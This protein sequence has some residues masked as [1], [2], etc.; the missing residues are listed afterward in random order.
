MTCVASTS[1]WG[2]CCCFLFPPLLSPFHANP[3]DERE[4]ERER[5]RSR[6]GRLIPSQPRISRPPRFICSVAAWLAARA[7][8]LSVCV[9]PECEPS[10]SY[11]PPHTT[12]NLRRQSSSVGRVQAVSKA[13]LSTNKPRRC[14]LPESFRGSRGG[15][16]NLISGGHSGR[17]EEKEEDEL[18][19]KPAKKKIKMRLG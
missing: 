2:C 8:L 3:V 14:R 13:T 10:P 18:E 16:T 15:H 11:A 19:R 7:W 1:G 5:V 12:S 4:S 6:L 17:R 9:S